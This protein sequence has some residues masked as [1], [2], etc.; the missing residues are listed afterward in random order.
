MTDRMIKPRTLQQGS[1]SSDSLESFGL[2]LRDWI[3]A[4]GRGADNGVAVV[5]TAVC[6]ESTLL[7]LRFESREH[8]RVRQQ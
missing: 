8:L 3:H 7:A 4:I 6:E 2:N 1:L 5:R